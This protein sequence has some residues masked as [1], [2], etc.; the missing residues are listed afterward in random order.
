[1]MDALLNSLRQRALNQQCQ[2]E[3]LLAV[4]TGNPSP[5]LSQ[6]HIHDEI[7]PASLDELGQKHQQ[8]L[9][10]HEQARTQAQDMLLEQ[11]R[12]SVSGTYVKLSQLLLKWSELELSIL[13]EI[14]RHQQPADPEPLDGAL[15]EQE[16]AMLE[17]FLLAQRNQ[18]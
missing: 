14:N 17:A 11:D 10:R 7:P 6:T 18:K 4:L 15:D 8:L 12:D 16:I 13:K 9:H 2:V 1:M 3:Q 5:P